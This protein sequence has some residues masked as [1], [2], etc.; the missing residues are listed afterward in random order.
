MKKISLT[1]KT[2]LYF[3]EIMLGG[4]ITEEDI[5][6]LTGNIDLETGDILTR[7]NIMGDEITM[8]DVMSVCQQ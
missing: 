1:R 5:K 2:L 8:E 6:S 7:E 4:D 3:L